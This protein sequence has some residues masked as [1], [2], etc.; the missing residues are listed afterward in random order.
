MCGFFTK[1][2]TR[3]VNV[4]LEKWSP[5]FLLTYSQSAIVEWRWEP[6]L[7]RKVHVR[8]PC[9]IAALLAIVGIATILFAKVIGCTPYLYQHKQ[10]IPENQHL[11]PISVKFLV[12]FGS[13]LID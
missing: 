2:H 5:P 10:L 1:V 4:M 6:S 8:P 13:A 9:C 3:P 11:S 12:L 7:A